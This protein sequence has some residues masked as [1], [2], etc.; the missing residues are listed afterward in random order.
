[1]AITN[2][3]IINCT[4]IIYDTMER[5]LQ[6]AHSIPSDW[7]PD[8]RTLLFT[9]VGGGVAGRGALGGGVSRHG[10]AAGGIWKLRLDGDRQPEVVLNSSAEERH[11]Q[12]SPDAN[13]MAYS[14]NEASR[15]EVFV[16]S[17]PEL[18]PRHQISIGG[19]GEP[20]WSPDGRE[21]FFRERDQM[22]VVE[23][24]HDPFR[25]GQPRVLFTGEYD[26]APVSGHQH[27]DISRD[28]KKFL[29]IKHGDPVGP[30][31]VRVVLNWSEE[32]KTRV[33]GAP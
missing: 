23:I 1:M 22:F 9:Q 5:L 3:T 2:Q 8:G 28:G 7:L 15:R 29:M 14:A 12:L 27:Y 21:L 26:A 16:Q 18:G 4:V 32:L 11:P 30:N 10:K 17:F 19:G 33:V 13:W 6:T 20:V 25:A 31:A 24:N